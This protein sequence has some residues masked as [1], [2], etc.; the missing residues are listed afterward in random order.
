M[1]K[2]FGLTV[3]AFFTALVIIITAFVSLSSITMNNFCEMKEYAKEYELKKKKPSIKIY[4]IYFFKTKTSHKRFAAMG[5]LTSDGKV[6]LTFNGVT[7]CV[8][9]E[10]LKIGEF[11]IIEG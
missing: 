7:H 8:S 9:C 10:K 4:K 11:N 2:F 3:A 6:I 1:L 5:R